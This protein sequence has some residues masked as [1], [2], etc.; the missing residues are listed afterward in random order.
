[1]VLWFDVWTYESGDVTGDWNKFIFHTEN[2]QDMRER[3][4]MQ[5]CSDEAGAYN[6]ATAL[7]L[8]AAAYTADK[9]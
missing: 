1:M 8:A 4:F 9:A 5:A 6:F 7:D 2:E 3:A